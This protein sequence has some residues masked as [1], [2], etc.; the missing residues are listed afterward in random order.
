MFRSYIFNKSVRCS[1]CSACNKYV[2]RSC[3][4]RPASPSVVPAVLRPTVMSVASAF[5]VQQV[6]LLLPSS[7]SN[8][9]VCL[10]LSSKSSNHVCYSCLLCPTGMSVAP[11]L[12]VQ[13]V[14]LLFLTSRSNSYVCYSC[15]LRL[16]RMFVAPDF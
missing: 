2:C 16:I 7:T 5:Y 4:L 11:V 8:K 1:C 15:L 13:H 6:C 12:Y 9:Y 3:L 14:R 10:L